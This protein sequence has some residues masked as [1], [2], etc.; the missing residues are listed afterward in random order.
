M[1]GL[2]PGEIVARFAAK[3]RSIGTTYVKAKI[4]N[5][6]QTGN[7]NARSEAVSRQSERVA[8]TSER[9]WLKRELHRNPVQFFD[10]L[11][12]AFRRKFGWRISR[13]ML[14]RAL[15]TAGLPGDQD[16][17]KLSLKKVERIARQ[18]NIAKRRSFRR[19]AR[20]IRAAQI[21]WLDESSMADKASM[22]RLGWAPVGQAAKQPIR[23]PPPKE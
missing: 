1:L 7:P 13:K 21:I 23:Q 3:H 2:S 22:H 14:S 9:K 17:L 10:Q 6:R 12:G 8:T 15:K 16:D 20:R 11:Q 5:Y 18:R 4:R 19:A